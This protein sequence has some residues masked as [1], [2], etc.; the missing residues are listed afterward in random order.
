MTNMNSRIQEL[1]KT[2]R[3]T[4]DQ[5]AKIIGTDKKTIYQI[6][7][8]RALVSDLLIQAICKKL[9]I[10][11]NWLKYG[12]ETEEFHNLQ[13]GSAAKIKSDLT[14]IILAIDD[15]ILHQLIYTISNMFRLIQY[16]KPHPFRPENIEDI[17][18]SYKNELE[19]EKKEITYIVLPNIDDIKNN[20]FFTPRLKE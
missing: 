18:L 2:M 6:E 16:D 15:T 11:I 8:N 17:L 14:N 4:Q 1:R 5:F 3:L 20:T 13:D 19:S 12:I 10:D 7:N 9:R